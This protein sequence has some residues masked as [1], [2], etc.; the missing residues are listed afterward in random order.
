MAR[1]T[2][3]KKRPQKSE[4]LRQRAT[5]SSSEPKVRRL[6]QAQAIATSPFKRLFAAI[7]RI[8]KPFRFLLWP[9][10]TKPFRLLGRFLSSILF[11][12]YFRDSWRELRLVTWPG[13][14]ET[15]QLT[16]AVFL[17]AIVFGL[18]VAIT[19]YGLDKIFRKVLLQQ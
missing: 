14:R 17:F 7:R 6:R 4:T 1:T 13:R 12:R 9:F 15:F 11:L 18:M 8:L 5:S 19:D 3:L 2:K 16:M 10:K